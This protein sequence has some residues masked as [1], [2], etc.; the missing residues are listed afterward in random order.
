MQMATA[1][2]NEDIK[3][4]RKKMKDFLN[5]FSSSA[6]AQLRPQALVMGIEVQR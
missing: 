2:R 3:F 6:Q 5:H 1:G 4:E